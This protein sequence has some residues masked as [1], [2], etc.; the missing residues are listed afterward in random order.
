MVI[1]RKGIKVEFQKNDTIG[2][3]VSRF[4]EKKNNVDDLLVKFSSLKIKRDYEDEDEDVDIVD[5]HDYYANIFPKNVDGIDLDDDES[6]KWMSDKFYENMDDDNIKRIWQN[7]RNWGKFHVKMPSKIERSIQ[8]VIFETC[9][10][11]SKLMST[12]LEEG[13]YREIHFANNLANIKSPYL[14][15][16]ESILKYYKK[17]DNFPEET[18]KRFFM[19][20][21]VSMFEFTKIK[22]KKIVKILF[23]HCWDRVVLGDKAI[24]M[25]DCFE[26]FIYQTLHS[27]YNG[28]SHAIKK[29]SYELYPGR[30]Y[31]LHFQDFV[32]KPAFQDLYSK[33][34]LTIKEY[35]DF[36]IDIITLQLT[37]PHISKFIENVA[38]RYMNT[39]TFTNF[40]II[41][42]SD[43]SSH[44][45]NSKYDDLTKFLPIIKNGEIYINVSIYPDEIYTYKNGKLHG[46]YTGY[47]ESGSIRCRLRYE[48]GLM[49]GM[50]MWFWENGKIKR[51]CYM[52]DEKSEGA[53]SAYSKDGRLIS[54]T[55]YANDLRNG[56]EYQY[57]EDGSIKINFYKDGDL[58]K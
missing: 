5:K 56:K 20:M 52:I 43:D 46:D 45:Y 41:R 44:H 40:D 13:G 34:G 1:S 47:Y 36:L 9:E 2:G 48:Y 7:P 3:K 15:K 57:L 23:E 31:N 50:Q 29:L 17:N 6:E 38:E 24:G 32:D 58:L 51:S 42:K 21:F 28:A 35:V 12:F 33:P 11:N 22:N 4:K 26:I 49:N 27:L 16:E 10:Y 37:K 18:L 19:D 8:T 53:E 25:Y 55:T 54:V 14:I 30:V 39:A